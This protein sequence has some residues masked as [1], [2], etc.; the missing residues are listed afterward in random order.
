MVVLVRYWL[1]LVLDYGI[2]DEKRNE[3]KRNIEKF[4][5]N[6]WRILGIYDYI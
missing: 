3:D 6:R 1:F 2:E 4:V 5:V